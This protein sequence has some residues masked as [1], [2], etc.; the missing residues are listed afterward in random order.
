MINANSH[1]PL[2]IIIPVYNEGENFPRL[3]EALL[4]SVRSSFRV[5]VV[6]DFDEDN[7]LPAVHGLVEKGEK[8]LRLIKNAVRPGVVSAILTAFRQVSEGPVLVVMADLADDLEQVDQMVRL[9]QQGYHLVAGSPSMRG[10]KGIPGPPLT[11]ALSRWA[12]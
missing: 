1:D 9:Y 12:R 5:L 8:R 10:G 4:T 7:T 11:P 3:W 2:T 6:F